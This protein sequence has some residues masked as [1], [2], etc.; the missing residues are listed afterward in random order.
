MT[1]PSER[2]ARSPFPYGALDVL[3]AV[4]ARGSISAAADSL[5]ITQ[6]T[7]SLALRRLE[8][9]TGLELVARS[10]RGSRLTEA[11]EVT[12]RSAR[13][14]LDSLGRFHEATRVLRE[15]VGQRLRIAAS[16]TV[17]EYVLPQF[18]VQRSGEPESPHV[19]LAVHNS[20]VVMAMVLAGS[21]DLGFVEGVR[22]KPGL[23]SRRI[24]SD[25]LAVVV[26]SKHDWA[27]RRSPVHVDELLQ[28]SLVLRE[29]GS[30][31][32]EVL[33]EGLR[34]LGRELPRHVPELGSTS[35]IKAAVIASESVAVLSRRAV[36]DETA[37]GVFFE[38]TV[39]EL[40]LHRT[41]RMVWAKNRPVR[42][43]TRR[44]GQSIVEA[45]SGGR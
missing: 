40:V 41:F 27:G 30:G 1:E 5:G 25:D 3:V 26:S 29:K 12:A 38:L 17:A 24:D 20:D 22:V 4:S 11:G 21:A 34:K 14:V 9:H 7:A 43:V 13:E 44:F 45:A 28:A 10:P 2:T 37:R 35:A 15:G 36:A 19:E 42:E 39:P 16:L 6:P 31:T 18:L 8:N 33:E 32:R 23:R